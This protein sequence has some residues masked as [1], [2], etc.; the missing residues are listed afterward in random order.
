MFQDKIASVSKAAGSNPS[1]SLS[2]N[3][4]GVGVSNLKK[5]YSARGFLSQ[6]G[7]D[8]T[9]VQPLFNCYGMLIIFKYVCLHCFLMDL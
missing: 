8:V 3:P 5:I 7:R 4:R 2:S 9:V 6:V 1:S